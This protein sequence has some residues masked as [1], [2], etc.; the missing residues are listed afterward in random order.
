MEESLHATGE[1]VPA[2]L[3]DTTKVVKL[4]LLFDATQVT[5]GTPD[6]NTVVVETATVISNP[7]YFVDGA[8]VT[9][10]TLAELVA[11][12]YSHLDLAEELD[13]LQAKAL[14]EYY[15]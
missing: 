5:E 6:G 11:R 15:N 8:Q 10:T 3:K 12:D 14:K 7:E 13:R 1:L 4:T 9:Y 2:N